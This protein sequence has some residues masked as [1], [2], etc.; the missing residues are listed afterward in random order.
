MLQSSSFNQNSLAHRAS[1]NFNQT[2]INL[3]NLSRILEEPEFD[4][5]T[6][7]YGSS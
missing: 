7:I 6:N 1:L 3:N 2:S 5:W 4:K